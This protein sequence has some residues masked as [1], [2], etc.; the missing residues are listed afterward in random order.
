MS[1]NSE[2]WLNFYF[3]T[4]Q[5]LIEI[6]GKIS[7][8]LM[9]GTDTSKVDNF[10]GH[11]YLKNLIEILDSISVNISCGITG[12]ST[13]ILNRVVL[14]YFFGATYLFIDKDTYL[15]K[16]RDIAFISLIEERKGFEPFYKENLG[17]T[18]NK[19][20]KQYKLNAEP[21]LSKLDYTKNKNHYDQLLNHSDFNIV[22]KEFNRTKNK[23]FFKKKQIVPWYSLW[24]GPNTIEV[25][26]HKT[27]TWHIYDTIYR[28]FSLYLHGHITIESNKIHKNK[29][30]S[31]FTYS[32]RTP[33][34]LDFVTTPSI[35]IC[36]FL[37]NKI[38]DNYLIDKDEIKNDLRQI[39]INYFKIKPNNEPFDPNSNSFIPFPV[40]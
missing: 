37:F 15:R 30:G 10:S 7:F 39:L 11:L 38:I 8:E 21:E 9:N 6:G 5:S 35:Y 23:D 40:G 33:Y 12:A 13:K 17:K 31:I 34:E 4:T 16:C 29:D 36:N 19:L 22:N 24:D 28:N 18:S 14:E 26:S 25:L 2:K 3:E 27:G 20:K 1:S 32:L